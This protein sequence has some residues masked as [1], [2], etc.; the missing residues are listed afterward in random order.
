MQRQLGS[1]NVQVAHSKHFFSVGSGMRA[2]VVIAMVILVTC[3]ARSDEPS[4]DEPIRWQEPFEAISTSKTGDALVLVVITNEDPFLNQEL[5][6]QAAKK[7]AAGKLDQNPPVW[8][9]DVLTLACRKALDRRADLRGRLT[10]QS[11]AAGLPKELTGGQTRNTPSRAVI[12]L[13]DGDYRLL[14]LTVGVPDTDDLLTLIE[15][16]EDVATM[17]QLHA[18]DEQSIVKAIAE[19]S[20]QRVSRLW[21][22]AL[23]EILVAMQGDRGGDEGAANA[24]RDFDGRM[25]LLS[26][27]FDP[28]YLADV[29]LRFGLTEST[30]QTRLV[31]LEQHPE[32][33]QPWCDAMIPFIAGSDVAVVWRELVESIWGHQPITSDA[34]A[35]ELL[36][37]F[38][39]LTKTEAVVLSLESPVHSRRV[40][41]P[42]V[43]DRFANRGIGWQ[44]VHA[45]ALEHPFRSVDRQQVAALIHTRD[46]NAVDIQ[47]PS[48]ARYLFFDPKKKHPLVVREG[49]PPGRFAGILKRSRSNLVNP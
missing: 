25:R 10:L 38:D 2:S 6:E 14:A 3:Y 35:K 12:A 13:C 47:R 37:W 23:E 20:H 46:L 26:E 5:L 44:G 11:I 18:D 42:P 27:T 41:W 32:A 16:G 29:K 17:R 24:Q 39:L 40:P 21:R 36:D 1:V 4:S 7:A 15:D 8:C 43:T 22:G 48:T 9:A 33:R 19:R 31:I 28:P 49:D 30:D 45:L 34:D